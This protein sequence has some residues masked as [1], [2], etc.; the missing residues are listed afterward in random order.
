MRPHDYYLEGVLLRSIGVYITESSGWQGLPKPKAPKSETWSDQ[1]GALIYGTQHLLY[2][3][4]EISLKCVI[5]ATEQQSKEQN[6]QRLLELLATNK[7]LINLKIETAQGTSHSFDVYRSERIDLS[8]DK[9]GE[10][11]L[12]HIKLTEPQATHSTL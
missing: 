12:T 10:A 3:P 4:R 11:I 1:N 8:A 6:A 7:P 5:I 2:E 9:S